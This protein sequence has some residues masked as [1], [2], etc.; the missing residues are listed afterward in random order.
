MGQIKKGNVFFNHMKV[1]NPW[2]DRNRILLV[3]LMFYYSLAW[4][5]ASV[6]YASRKRTC[7]IFF[8]YKSRWFSTRRQLE[9]KRAT[10]AD[11]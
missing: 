8:M 11:A 3:I 7:R 4:K 6:F 1:I 10:L 5:N 9:F 2:E